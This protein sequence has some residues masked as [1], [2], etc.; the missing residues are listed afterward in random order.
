MATKGQISHINNRK[1]C[2][3]RSN[4]ETFSNIFVHFSI[5]NICDAVYVF[6]FCATKSEATVQCIVIEFDRPPANTNRLRWKRVSNL[7]I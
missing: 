5:V 7:A 4:N 1:A 2:S 6:E 3:L